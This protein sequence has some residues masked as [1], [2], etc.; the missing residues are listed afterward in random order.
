MEIPVG[1]NLSLGKSPSSL[2]ESAVSGSKSSNDGGFSEHFEDNVN[3]L[4]DVRKQTNTASSKQPEEPV[5]QKPS[6]LSNDVTTS[7]TSA[8]ETETL[9]DSKQMPE[10]AQTD[11]SELPTGLETLLKEDGLV[12]Q[13]PG[14]LHAIQVVSDKRGISANADISAE[15]GKV[16]PLSEELDVLPGDEVVA[17]LNALNKDIHFDPLSQLN[18]STAHAASF[19]AANFSDLKGT[20]NVKNSV[21]D[22]FNASSSAL[23]LDKPEAI[24]I[25]EV[26]IDKVLKSSPEINLAANLSK[27]VILTKTSANGESLLNNVSN[28]A[29]ANQQL[30][31]SQVLVDKPMLQLETPMGNARWGQDFNQRVQWMVGQSMNGAQIRLTPQH[32]GPVEVR[33]HVQNDQTT[34]S[35]TAQHGATREAI[36]AAL[37]KLREMLSEQNINLVDVDIS[38][39]SFAEQRDQ[40]ALN[41]DNDQ[42][43]SSV[44]P[45]QEESLFNQAS[46]GQQRVY[47][48]LFSDF[49]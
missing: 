12:E 3:R 10:Q 20:F 13:A 23:S 4:K 29:A 22:F 31:T 42:S 28:I 39:H 34:I 15:S 2:N 45:D 17:N 16:L 37:P 18:E 26:V 38:Q 6:A 8:S 27:D 44:E 21:T 5:T 25:S 30:P 9:V 47:S 11:L 1:L 7:S 19:A 14:L 46:N 43:A 35:F 33:I 32:M 40:Q 48:G 41:K 49:A 24:S 36:D